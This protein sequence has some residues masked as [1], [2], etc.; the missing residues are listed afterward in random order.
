MLLNALWAQTLS[1]L[2]SFGIIASGV[3]VFW[4]WKNRS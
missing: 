3:P 4:V 2:Y 1:T